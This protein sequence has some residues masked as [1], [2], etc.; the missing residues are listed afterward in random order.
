MGLNNYLVAGS[1]VGKDKFVS[2]EI[3]DACASLSHCSPIVVPGR[4]IFS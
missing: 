1:L 2:V 4:A 3:Y